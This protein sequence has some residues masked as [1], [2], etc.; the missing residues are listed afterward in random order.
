MTVITSRLRYDNRGAKLPSHESHGNVAVRRVWS[1]RSGRDNIAERAF[2]YLSFYLSASITLW[3]LLRPGDIVVAKTDPP[4]LSIPTSF[5]THLKSARLINWLQ[6][7]FPEVAERVGIPGTQVRPVFRVLRRLRNRS[8][9]SAAMNVVPG[10]GMAA[11]LEREGL[12]TDRVRVI[13]NWSDGNKI[14]PI[15]PQEN[16]LRTRWN[17]GSSFVVGY[18]GNLGRAHEFETIIDA[19]S[20]HQERAGAAPSRDVIHQ[21]K[22]LIVGDGAQRKVLE[23]EI[24]TRRLKNV[25]LQPYQPPELLSQALAAADI[26]LVSLRPELEGLVVP[27]KFYGIVAAGR[28]MIFVGSPQGEIARL[29][30]EAKCGVTVRSGD[31]EALL[32]QL[33]DFAR[34]QTKIQRMGEQA[35][36]A[37]D[38]L[39]D[40][41]HALEKWQEVIDS[42]T[43]T[44]CLNPGSEGKALSSN[45][46]NEAS[47]IGS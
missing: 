46:S 40:K 21:I 28:P 38:A 14:R 4:L 22:F 26:H 32:T 41:S 6:D 15:V 16:D 36:A 23:R 47:T 27:S 33:I 42:V 12:V 43:G 2:E 34:D 20:L 8:L 1:F 30:E 10:A 25:Q 13:P 19:M 17:L 29:V 3:R 35:R 5:I 7:L 37:F 24:A 11:T 39:W 44:A 9:R 18:V 31:S 45:C